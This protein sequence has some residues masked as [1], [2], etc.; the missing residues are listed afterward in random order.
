MKVRGNE[1]KIKELVINIDMING[2]VKEG[3]LAAPSIMRVVP[4]QKILL[5]R[6]HKEEDKGIIFIRDEHT[7]DSVEFKTFP[8]HCVKGTKEPELIDDL[9]EYEEDA[10]TFTKNSTNFVFA[11]GFIKHLKLFTGLKKVYLTGC[12]SEICVKNGGITL[13]NFFDQE[14]MDIEVCVVSN[15]ID[16]YEAPGHTTD[17]VTN[18][19][20][21]DMQANGIKVLTLGGIQ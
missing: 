18:N 2:F 17:Q 6:F 16:T 7:L 10:L 19:A 14:N 9:K 5:D 21:A 13:R 3:A 11:P 8:V 4:Y 20:I 12:L 15:L 1:G